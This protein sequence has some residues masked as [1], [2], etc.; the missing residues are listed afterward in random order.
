MN[1]SSKRRFIF[2]VGLALFTFLIIVMVIAQR[3]FSISRQVLA[4]SRSTNQFSIVS[5]SGTN[6]LL[7]LD[8]RA[9]PVLLSWS[10]G[11]DPLWYKWVD[12]LRSLCRMSP[13]P[14]TW[15]EKS[16]DARHAFAV[17]GEHATS[18]VPALVQ[19]LADP[20][21]NTRRT[22]IHML[23]AIGSSIGREAFQKMTNCLTDPDKDVRNDVVWAIQCHRPQEY[24]LK[25]SSP[26]IGPVAATCITWPGRMRRL[27][28]IAWRRDPFPHET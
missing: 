6:A 26:F 7:T 20:D 4:A 27:D 22:S 12:R 8:E 16:E 2:A 25:P 13:L 14:S 24:P 15:F 9:I 5:P 28:W 11:H 1:L 21:P 19:Q 10:Q 18:A 17:L 3:R 23:G